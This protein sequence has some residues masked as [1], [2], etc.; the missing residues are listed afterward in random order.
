M[1]RAGVP[2]VEPSVIG[3]VE[4]GMETLGDPRWRAGREGGSRTAGGAVPRLDRGAKTGR[5]GVHRPP[6]GG[7]RGAG[8]AG[9]QG[10]GPHPGR[11]RSAV[12]ARRARSL[13][14]RQPGDGRR[15]APPA[16]A[17]GR[18]TAAGRRGAGVASVPACLHPD[19]PARVSPSPRIP[20]ATSSTC[21]SSPP[22]AA[23]PKPTSGSPPSR[24][25]S[26]AC[27]IPAPTA[28]DCRC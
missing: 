14:H 20:N 2:R 28:R 15:R 4:F 11:H 10:G 9:G 13:P 1:P 18:E 25:C 7:R 22:A 5:G 19:E 23:R 3:A 6:P 17:G 8:A 16:G 27:A 26:A 24:S 21:C 12:R